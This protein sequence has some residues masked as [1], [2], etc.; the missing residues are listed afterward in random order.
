[1]KNIDSFIEDYLIEKTE[2][3]IQLVSNWGTGKTHYYR[4]TLDKKIRNTSV[5]SDNTKKY[6]PIYISLFGL[7]SIEEISTKIVF[8][9]YQ[10]KLFKGYFT[11]K[12]KKRLKVTGSIFKIG[13]QGFL[14]FKGLGSA[15]DYLTDV[16]DVGS[17]ALNEN[18]IFICFDDLERKNSALSI[19]DLIGYINSLV[20]VGVKVLILVN[21]D[22]LKKDS[23]NYND[24]K[25]KVIDI[26]IPFNIPPEVIIKSIIKDRYSNASF[27][28]YGSFLEQNIGM[29]IKISD[30]INNNYRHLIYAL[31]CYQKCYSLFQLKIVSVDHELKEIFENNVNKIT[32]LSLALA[33]EY[34][35]SMLSY[36]DKDK[37]KNPVVLM[38]DIMLSGNF[39][40]STNVDSN[41]EGDVVIDNE[42]NFNLFIK[43]YGIKK[44]NY[45]FFTTIFT[46]LT[47][48][49]DFNIEEFIDEF[50][51]IFNVDNGVILPEYQIMNS[52]SYG[53][54]FELSDIEYKRNTLE[55]IENAKRAKYL[56]SE[57]LTVIHYVERYDN[58]LEL[59]IENVFEDIKVGLITS[60]K[61]SKEH[62][63]SRFKMTGHSELS[64][65]NQK[66]IDFGIEEIRKEKGERKGIQLNAIKDNLLESPA[67]FFEQYIEDSTLNYT[68]NDYP[69]FSSITESETFMMLKEGDKRV[70]GSFKKFLE[71][72]YQNTT[73]VPIEANH[74]NALR[75]LL[76][77]YVL[78]L[79]GLGRKWEEYFIKEII[80]V[81]NKYFP[82]T[83]V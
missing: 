38:N 57:Y 37:L 7:K 78:E 27:Q 19:N 67:E 52:L 10:S 60:I 45:T 59:N 71:E 20:D 53:S 24:L 3:A 5:F 2:Y 9:F 6:K 70:L 28:L 25:E 32:L 56:P 80:K 62:E 69:M 49:S 13:L 76:I 51:S 50:N 22:V 30:S 17:N 75:T 21:E 81:L 48:Y 35:S 72:R 29:L 82:Q 61:K 55:L 26:S 63:F 41:N 44:N 4:N 18:E 23:E 58:L 66:V 16:K 64:H 43:K 68:V 36:K 47:N 31:K 34:K 54:C 14:N 15:N 8:E 83:S 73:L 12:G 46:H 39:D 42:F 1:M 11:E 77:Q 74:M 33:V 40:Q 65:I 79:N